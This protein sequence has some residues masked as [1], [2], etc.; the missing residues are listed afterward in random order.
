MA[1]PLFVV[2]VTYRLDFWK[3]LQPVAKVRQTCR[4]FTPGCKPAFFTVFLLRS[5][6]NTGFLMMHI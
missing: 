6:G 1:Q 2:D 3:T 5:A 4:A